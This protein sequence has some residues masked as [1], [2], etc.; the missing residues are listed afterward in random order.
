MG[1]AHFSLY[2][3]C[4]QEKERKT[5]PSFFPFLLQQG[6]GLVILFR[7]PAGWE[8]DD[9]VSQR[10]I[11][12]TFGCS[13]FYRTKS[14]VKK[15]VC[16]CV[17]CVLNCVWFFGTPWTVA[18]SLLCPWDFPGKSTGVG[19]YFLLQGILPNCCKGS[20]FQPDSGGDVLI[21]SL[22]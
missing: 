18:C 15:M 3:L 10:T 7:K 8:D 4:S 14:K 6:Q 17:V 1:P 19:C 9:L 16:V 12:L 5:P 2:L 11:L 13:F 22:L 21:F 20:W